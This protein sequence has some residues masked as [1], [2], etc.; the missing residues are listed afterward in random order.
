M[1]NLASLT[2]TLIDY[3]FGLLSE[4]KLQ[5]AGAVVIAFAL[6]SIAFEFG[7]YLYVHF[8]RPGKDLK[9]SYGEW[10]VV[11]GASDGI[12]F[13]MAKEFVRKG[14]G[15]V[16]ISRH[17][18]PEGQQVSKLQGRMK[19]ILE[20]Y[21][22]AQVR[23]IEVDFTNFDA[24]AR[25]KVAAGLA[26]LN[27]GV[28]VN[29]VGQSYPFPM[30]FHEL[31]D[32]NVEQLMSVNVNSTTWMTRM[33]L[34]GMVEKKKGAVINIA[35]AAGIINS[36]LLTQYGAAKS[37]IAMMTRALHAEYEGRGISFQCQV[38]MFVTTKLAKLKHTTLFTCSEAAYARAAVA[39]IGYEPLISPYWSHA[40]QIWLGTT[41]PD[42]II[43]PLNMYMHGDL[44]KRGMKKVADKAKTS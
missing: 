1:A 18:I 33:V 34:P 8:V 41:L 38:P 28:L 22:N 12:G 32:A 42:G 30:Y 14:L 9:R 21:P 37:Y 6:V 3:S 36:P 17:S 20:K 15:V 7:T 31:S 27:V 24:E 11:T 29:N 19:E 16:L 4:R 5:T 35:S 23:V 44:R 10:A 13:A 43:S 26:G 40:I 25:K 2:S 39:A